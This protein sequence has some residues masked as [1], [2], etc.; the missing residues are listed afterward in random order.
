[1]TGAVLGRPVARMV[2]FRQGLRRLVQRGG[3][4]LL[5]L[6]RLSGLLFELRSVGLR[7]CSLSRSRTEIIGRLLH[8]ISQ[9][10]PFEI[11]RQVARGALLVL[12]RISTPRGSRTF[13]RGCLF[14]TL[15]HA[16]SA[17][18]QPLLIAGKTPQLVA[19]R[20]ALS[21]AGHV[22]CGLTLG[23]GELPRLHL[24]VAKCTPPLVGP[25]RTQLTL[26]FLQFFKGT[27]ASRARFRGIL[28]AQFAGGAA[29]LLRHIAHLTAVGPAGR[30]RGRLAALSGLASRRLTLLAGLLI[31][32]AL[33]ALVRLGLRLA[34]LARSLLGALLAG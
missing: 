19:R 3:E 20:L 33:A 17:V 13:W 26:E 10:L 34:L 4:V 6:R 8:A 12:V 7:A 24:K 9:A 21:D 18:G 32:S 15:L 31:L 1:V 2:G 29:H 27:R 23:I 22:G 16:A 28:P 5:A 30:R 25:I 14:E 11:A